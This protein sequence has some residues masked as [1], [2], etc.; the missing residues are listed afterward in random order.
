MFTVVY[1]NLGPT[2]CCSIKI[3]RLWADKERRL[4]VKVIERDMMQSPVRYLFTLRSIL[5]STWMWYRKQLKH[6]CHTK[7]IWPSSPQS[8]SELEDERD[9]KKIVLTLSAGTLQQRLRLRSFNFT[10]CRRSLLCRKRIVRIWWLHFQRGKFITTIAL[11][12]LFFIR[13]WR[14]D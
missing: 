1:S 4:R 8:D 6:I 9:K 11:A 3:Y 14:L 12:G 10:C 13:I 2:A 7:S 5:L